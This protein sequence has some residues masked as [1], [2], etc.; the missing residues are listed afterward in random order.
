MKMICIIFLSFIVILCISL[1]GIEALHSMNNRLNKIVNNTAAKIKLGAR[2]NQNL[3]EITRSEKN[4]ILARDISEI[5]QYEGFI[6]ET[7]KQMQERCTKLREL[8]NNEGKVLLDAFSEN[9]EQFLEVH[10]EVNKLARI[11]VNE[12]SKEAN[13]KIIQLSS[14]K[15]R[16][17]ADKAQ[18]LIT[19]I[20]NLND[21]ALDL[22]KKASDTNYAFKRNLMVFVGISGLGMIMLCGL[23]LTRSIICALS[24]LFSGLNAFSNNELRETSDTFMHILN[25]LREGSKHVTQASGQ[26]AQASSTIAAGSQEQASS[27]EETSASLEEISSMIKLNA[28]NAMKA[29]KLMKKSNLT[30]NNLAESMKKMNQAS[31]ETGKIIKTIDEISFQTNLLA[32]NAAVEAA[33]AGETGA[34]F[35]VVA[36]EVRNL[37]M[38]AAAAAQNTSTLIESIINSVKE[39]S[40]HVGE[41]SQAFNQIDKL[42]GGIASASDEQ[43]RGIEQLNIAMNEMD[44]VV[45]QNASVSEEA[46]ASSEELNAQAKELMTIVTSLSRIT[47]G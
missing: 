20:V 2:I 3:I 40:T 34:G 27:I 28:Q 24:E 42:V 19:S 13:S 6:E 29:D 30:M 17:L 8:V 5:N 35:A 26:M 10:K 14:V 21:K 33:R 15:G 4:I 18:S 23:L 31:E 1:L 22:D 9:W 12:N 36:D 44:S 25:K 45:Q 43:A 16:N 7:I 47:V 38:R 32:L 46:A 11:A 37:A 41:T 39:G